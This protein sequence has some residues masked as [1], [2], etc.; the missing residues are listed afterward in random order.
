MNSYLNITRNRQL[1]C[2]HYYGLLEKRLKRFSMLNWITVLLPSI[3]GVG[4][5]SIYFAGPEYKESIAVCAGVTAI[6]SAIHKGMNCEAH[7]ADCRR[8]MSDYR[9]L[10]VAYRSLAEIEQENYKIA[11]LSLDSKFGALTRTDTVSK[12][13]PNKSSN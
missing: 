13:K 10:S 8:L 4:A 2:E 9:A 11:L 12:M 6:L 1:E 5:A 7:Q 3:L